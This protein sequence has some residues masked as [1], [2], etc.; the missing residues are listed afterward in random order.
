MHSLS[1]HVTKLL[2]IESHSPAAHYKFTSQQ[3]M[4]LAHKAGGFPSLHVRLEHTATV[5]CMAP[6]QSHE[7]F[8]NSPITKLSSPLELRPMKPSP[9]HKQQTH[10][11]VTRLMSPPFFPVDVSCTQGLLSSE[12]P[13]SRK[14][15]YPCSNLVS[16]L[17]PRHSWPSTTP[18]LSS[19]FTPHACK[20]FLL[21][22]SSFGSSVPVTKGVPSRLYLLQIRP[23]IAAP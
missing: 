8:T 23:V 17:T 1:V 18:L 12:Q 10:L 15:C 22:M 2:I 13:T 9:M 16:S 21:C 3:T 5:S 6:I 7:S 19:Y 11:H 4:M 20:L 14:T